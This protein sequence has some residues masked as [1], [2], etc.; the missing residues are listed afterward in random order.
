LVK[1]REL[2]IVEGP[3]HWNALYQQR[4]SPIGG[5]MFQR[6]WFEVRST[7][8]PLLRAVRYW[9]LAATE[10]LGSRDP[11]Y[12]VGL[13]MGIDRDGTYW[14]IDCIRFRGD[15]GDVERTLKTVAANDSALPAYTVQSPVKTWI[16]Q[17]P[18]AGAK[19]AVRNLIIRTLAGYPVFADPA[20]SM[21]ANTIGRHN[22]I[23]RADPFSG[24]AKA[25][26]VKL[27]L[28]PWNKVLLDELSVFP[29]GAHDDI[30]DGCSGSFNQ[31]A[32]KRPGSS[33]TAGARDPAVSEWRPPETVKRSPWQEFQV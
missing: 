1:L 23:Q 28:A 26:N 19:L 13:L 6:E 12:T 22:K 21:G 11:D 31:L 15:P 20:G 30:M 16:E 7:A 32:L 24:Q 29:N 27:L 18:G 17:E 2:E 10:K 3:R 8:P 9:D 4:P 14:I 25:R 33:A 5:G